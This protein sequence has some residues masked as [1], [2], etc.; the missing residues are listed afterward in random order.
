[1]TDLVCGKVC[2]GWLLLGVVFGIGCKG[3]GFLGAAAVVLIM[4]FL[5]FRLRMMGAGD[6]KMMAV[7]AG[8]L[9]LEAGIQAIAAGLAVGA[10]WSLYRLWCDKSFRTRLMYFTAY[11]TR[12]FQE[13]KI[14]AYD[15]LSHTDSRHR[16]PLAACLAVG[17]FL[18][19]VC[20]ETAWSGGKI[21]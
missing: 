16:I 17:V 21:I 3:L 13:K 8:Y 1:M 11:F 7:I 14:V 9:G 10:I 6:C 2:N 20:S 15:E 12:I 5:L 19:L 4:V 18:Y